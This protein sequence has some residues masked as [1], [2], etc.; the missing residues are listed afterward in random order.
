MP[1]GKKQTETGCSGASRSEVDVF[2]S[3][4]ALVCVAASIACPA[5]GAQQLYRRAGI[6]SAGQLRIITS[7]GAEVTPPKDSGQVGF[8]Q[9]AISTDRRSVGWLALYPNCCTTYPI[10]L[11]LVVLAHGTR[12][13]ITGSGLPIWRWHFSEDGSK[14]A[15]RQAPVHWSAHAHFELRDTRSGRLLSSSDVDSADSGNVPAWARALNTP[16]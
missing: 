15:F 12:L 4:V 10:P 7:S 6:D 1:V 9:V 3:L 8:D 16:P 11:R 2:R 5:S 13:A 14:V